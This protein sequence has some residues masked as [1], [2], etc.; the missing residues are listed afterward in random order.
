[1][2]LSIA[3]FS[4]Q[5]HWILKPEFKSKHLPRKWRH[6]NLNIKH[7]TVQQSYIGTHLTMF[8][9]DAFGGQY[10]KTLTTCKNLL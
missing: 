1:M 4:Y 3:T 9:S 2:A 5:D 10:L 6:I 8:E 7:V